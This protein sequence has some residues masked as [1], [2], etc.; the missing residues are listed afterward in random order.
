MIGYDF[1][2]EP[3]VLVELF[4]DETEDGCERER[5]AALAKLFGA[6]FNTDLLSQNKQNSI[7]NYTNTH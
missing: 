7:I 5:A 2:Q 6:M 1:K 4:T 3:I